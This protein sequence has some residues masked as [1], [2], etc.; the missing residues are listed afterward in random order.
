MNKWSRVEWEV[1]KI[2]RVD[3]S[4]ESPYDP[5]HLSQQV[6]KIVRV[7]KLAYNIV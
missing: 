7:T 1:V 3:T 4:A 2:A 5:I 6:N